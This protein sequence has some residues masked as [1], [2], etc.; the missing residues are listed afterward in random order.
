MYFYLIGID[1]KTASF[2]QR[3]NL[4]RNSGEVARFWQNSVGTQ[5]AALLRTCNRIEIYGLAANADDAFS[6]VSRF[7]RACADFSTN[8]Y[9]KYTQKE[10]L[11][12]ALRLA[13]GLESQLKGEL[14]IS[15]QLKSWVARPDFPVG[16]KGFWQDIFYLSGLI[17]RNSGLDKDIPNIAEIV[18]SDAEKFVSRKR[19]AKI[20]VIGTG[21]I[22]TLLT[23]H[24]P[25][26]WLLQFVA[27]KNL[28]R[29][30]Y[31]AKESAGRVFSFRDLPQLFIDADILISATA[32][33]HYILG[34]RDFER[35]PDTR[36]Q[37]LFIYDLALPR[38]IE[39]A[40]S[41]NHRLFIQDMDDLAQGFQ[42]F[43]QE[44]AGRL[45]TAVGLI[46]EAVE[47]KEGLVYGRSN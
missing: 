28:S 1:Y 17:R 27:H 20:I 11:R 36:K 12:H 4:W 22:A 13:T 24:R 16:L 14:E 29:A 25:S 30:I 35:L 26:H 41:I 42:K 18:F 38:D 9:I 33:P 46:E 39:P 43:N 6:A 34:K 47:S 37:P 44:N 3:E 10:V 21:K 2:G 7:R 40:A 5:G 23:Q 45:R 8:A 15:E 19:S 31:L 32:S